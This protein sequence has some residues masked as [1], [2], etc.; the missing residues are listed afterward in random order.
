[1]ARRI[2]GLRTIDTTRRDTGDDEVEFC[3]ILR[4]DDRAAVRAFAG[5]DL[6]AAVLPPAALRVLR[7]YDT[8]SRQY[9]LAAHHEQPDT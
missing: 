4:F 3:T 2:A 9:D 1:M 5:A 8:E 7:C 6:A